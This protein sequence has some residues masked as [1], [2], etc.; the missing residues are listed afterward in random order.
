MP[1]SRR[2]IVGF[3]VLR[4]DDDDDE[5]NHDDPSKPRPKPSLLAPARLDAHAAP[6]V[7]ARRTGIEE[8]ALDLLGALPS[9]SATPGS[10]FGARRAAEASRTRGPTSAPSTTD[11]F[12]FA[13]LTDITESSSADAEARAA[14][15]WDFSA[16]LSEA[17][18]AHASAETER[19]ERLER[20]LEELAKRD[21]EFA[22]L[23]E[24]RRRLGRPGRAKPDPAA[25]APTATSSAADAH[26]Q[27]VR[28]GMPARL[29]PL[30]RAQDALDRLRSRK[31]VHSAKQE[32][33]A[34]RNKR[35]RAAKHLY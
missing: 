13:A 32:R 4:D 20:Q 14:P 24:V 35:R 18:E 5:D 29:L 31:E 17:D 15:K 6:S 12:L 16:L 8:P 33:K 22:A 26:A 9:T 3:S 27:A 25:A 30:A 21:E 2:G 10:G 28:R 23:M 34:E 19:A 7:A 1:K 11:S